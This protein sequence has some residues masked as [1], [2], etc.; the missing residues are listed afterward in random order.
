MSR[1]KG[2]DKFLY[3]AVS[4]PQDCSKRFTL[5]FPGR[6]VQSNTISTSLGN[7]QLY[8]TINARRLL[9]HISTTVYS[10]VYSVIQLRELEQCRV[11]KIAQGFITAARD[12]NPGS[13]SRESEPLPL[14]HC[15]Q[16]S[17]VEMHTPVVWGV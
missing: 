8:A 14:N 11:K 9:V 3:S 1:K 10:Q 6:P 7:I 12:S 4:N 5:Y 2:K 15:A 16:F 13:L 17:S